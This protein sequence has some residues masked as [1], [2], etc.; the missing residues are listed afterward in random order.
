MFM[1]IRQY[2]HQSH[3]MLNSWVSACKPV[4]RKCHCQTLIHT[5]LHSPWQQ[6]SFHPVDQHMCVCCLCVLYSVCMYVR[7]HFMSLCMSMSHSGLCWMEEQHSAQEVRLQHLLNASAK[8]VS[9]S[10]WALIQEARCHLKNNL[11]TRRMEDKE[12]GDCLCDSWQR[13]LK[14][15]GEKHNYCLEV[16][17]R[18]EA[19]KKRA[20]SKR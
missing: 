7:M 6:V 14:K 11:K 9:T 3:N 12:M 20:I 17:F 5:S 2:I 15:W 10:T 13:E 16:E 1:S 4:T 19:G 8:T 18:K